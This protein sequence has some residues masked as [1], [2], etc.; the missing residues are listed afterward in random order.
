MSQRE[1]LADAIAALLNETPEEGDEYTLAFE[2]SRRAMPYVDARDLKSVR[3]SV[4]AGTK[5]SERRTRTGFGHTYKPIIALSGIVTGADEPARLESL[6]R[7]IA[8][9]EEIEEVF[10]EFE[11]QLAGLTFIGFDESDAEPFNDENMRVGV[12]T[13]NI[14]L[15]FQD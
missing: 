10:E 15:E 1:E 14:T 3:V 12:F 2:A 8:L 5:S 13:T 11:G 7:F 6:S 4:L 9:T